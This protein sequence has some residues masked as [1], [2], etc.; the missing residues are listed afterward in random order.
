[1]FLHI[2]NGTISDNE[3]YELAFALASYN[4]AAPVG[5]IAG[6]P[7]QSLFE[8]GL[9]LNAAAPTVG[10]GQLGLGG[11]T[12]G[13]ASSGAGTLPGNPLGFL[14]ANVGGTTVKIPYYAS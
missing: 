4:S 9:I 11:T 7:G 2:S 12:A 5:S 13:T 14:V 8:D 3:A 1:V 6:M 10:P